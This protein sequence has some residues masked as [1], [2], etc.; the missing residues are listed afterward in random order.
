MPLSIRN[1]LAGEVVAV[2]TGEVMSTVRVR[3]SGELEVTAA[4]TL[5]AVRDL[6]LA[7]GSVVVAL[8]KSTEVA[9]GTGEVPRMSIRNRLPGRVTDVEHGAVMTTVRV[10]IDSG[11]TLT[12]AI[13][14]DAADD[15]GLAAGAEVTALVK[16]T[17]VSIAL[18]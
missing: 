6:G 9:L 17:E 8:V 16:S 4:I 2:E 18:P 3:L 15:L 5:D 7:P 13:T 12:A 1:R 11:D 10:A 14:K